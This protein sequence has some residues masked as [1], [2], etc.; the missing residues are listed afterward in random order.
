MSSHTVNHEEFV[1][2]SITE[3]KFEK[4]KNN[5]SQSNSKKNVIKYKK[6]LNK[7]TKCKDVKYSTPGLFSSK[8]NSTP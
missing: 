4:I 6:F 3:G 8:R 1:P 5:I 2:T 7:K